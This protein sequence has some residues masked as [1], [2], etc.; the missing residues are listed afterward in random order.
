MLFVE[1]LMANILAMNNT[2]TPTISATSCRTPCQPPR[3]GERGFTL[4]EMLVA[5]VVTVVLVSIAAPSMSALLDS[6]KLNSASSVFVAGFNLARSEAIRRSNRVVL[7][8]SGDGANCA[9]GGGWEQGWIVFHDDDNDGERDPSEKVVQREL[10]LAAGLRFTGNLNVA[11]YVSFTPSGVTSLVS[12]GFQAGTL[13]VCR[14][15]TQGGEARQII[16][17]AVGR[18][19]VHKAIVRSCA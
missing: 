1:N 2:A 6:I 19:R 3:R 13:T 15:S 10:P 9:A 8:K 7:C 16:L 12:G 5:V 4:V 18:P 11:R 17:N 14:L